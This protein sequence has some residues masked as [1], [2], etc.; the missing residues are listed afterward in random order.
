MATIALAAL[1][2]TCLMTEGC[3]PAKM[4]LMY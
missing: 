4:G 3:D 1:K 2:T